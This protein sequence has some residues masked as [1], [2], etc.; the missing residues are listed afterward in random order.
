VRTTGAPGIAALVSRLPRS[1]YGAQAIDL[2]SGDVTWVSPRAMTHDRVLTWA[3]DHGGVVPLPM[4][5]MWETEESL[6]RWLSD[7]EAELAR[8]FDRIAD[9]DEFGLRVHRRDEI[10]MQS[11]D[12]VDAEMAQLV[13]EAAAASPGQRYLL[14]RKLAERGKG[15]VRAASQRLSKE[16][17][18]QLRTRS[19]DALSLPLTPADAS[20]ATEGTLVLNA[21]FLVDRRQNGDFRAAVAALSRDHEPRGLAFDF[22]GPWPPYNFVGDRPG[23]PRAAAR[24]R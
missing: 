10:M 15:V 18:Q 3:H 17:Y 22:T 4:F 8:V 21:A 12:E 5:S 2:H 13:K 24:A 6:A 1:V 9:A 11:I 14:E 19:R 23:E 7:R 16:I 20:G